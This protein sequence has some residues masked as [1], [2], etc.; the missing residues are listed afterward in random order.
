M[1]MNRN[2]PG[3]ESATKPPQTP[4]ILGFCRHSPPSPLGYVTHVEALPEPIRGFGRSPW[5]RSV[6]YCNVPTACIGDAIGNA[7]VI[8]LK[9]GGLSRRYY[10]RPWSGNPAR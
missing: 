5:G 1:P 9:A 8:R 6:L 3:R 4:R 10:G 7:A 2:H